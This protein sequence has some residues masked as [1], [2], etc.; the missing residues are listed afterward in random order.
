MLEL[1]A[2]ENRDKINRVLDVLDGGGDIVYE[3]SVRGRLHAIEGTLTVIGFYTRLVRG[4]RSLLLL[5]CAVGTVAAAWYSA[6]AH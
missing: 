3:R 6:L 5:A 4:W 1:T 2:V